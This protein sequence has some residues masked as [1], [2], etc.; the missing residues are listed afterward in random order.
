[1]IYGIS[2]REKILIRISQGGKRKQKV[3]LKEH[4]RPYQTCGETSLS[5]EINRLP[6]YLN[7]KGLL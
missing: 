4:L 5:S 6:P 2:S 3:C 7:A 1:M